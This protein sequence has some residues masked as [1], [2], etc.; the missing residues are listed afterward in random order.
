MQGGPYARHHYHLPR[1]AAPHYRCSPRQLALPAP[2]LWAWRGA[3]D[4]SYW[5]ACAVAPIGATAQVPTGP[6]TA[7]LGAVRGG[8]H[9]YGGFRD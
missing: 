6:S 3:N 1:Y 7:K 9:H 5:S 4:R 8:F 2:R